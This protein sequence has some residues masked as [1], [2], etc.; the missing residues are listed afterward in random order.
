MKTKFVD[1]TLV[2]KAL[3]LTVAIGIFFNAKAWDDNRPQLLRGSAVSDVQAPLENPDLKG[4]RTYV[5]D[6]VKKARVQYNLPGVAVTI[7][8]D[9]EVVL[10]K[11]YGF[12]DVQ[13]QIKVNP[14][15]TL[16]RIGS[17][18]KTMTALAVMQLVEQ[19]KLSI[20]TDINEYLNE[21]KIP[22]TFEAP[23][24]IR[25]LL[26]HRAGFE[27]ADAGNLFV[28]NASEMLSAERYLA[29]HMPKRIW[30]PGVNVS[31][32]NYGFAL[33]GYLVELQSG[34]DLATYMEQH[35]FSVLGMQ[36]TTL[37]EPVNANATSIAMKPK[38]QQQ[39]ATGYFR[40]RKG[41]NIPKPF[42]FIGHVSGAG[43]ISATAHDMALY[44]SA[45]LSENNQLVQP[46]T[47]K[48]MTR[49]LYDDRALA[50]GIAHGMFDGWLKG[51]EL[52]AHSGATHTFS[53]NM[54]MFPEAQLGIFVSTN[55][56]GSGAHFVEALPTAIFN[57]YYRNKPLSQTTPPQLSQ[58]SQV[59]I[60][61]QVLK[62]Q[63]SQPNLE[64]YTGT[65]L[66]TRRSYTQLEKLAALD[67]AAEVAI[68]DQNRL[69]MMIAGDKVK[70]KHLEADVFQAGSRGA[71]IFYFYRDG[72]GKV[73][74]FSASMWSGDYE[75]VSFLQSPLFFNLAL[76]ISSLLSISILL[77]CFVRSRRSKI[78]SVVEKSA[79][80][81]AGMILVAALGFMLMN[82][83]VVL[84]E[85]KFHA[86][87][88]TIEVKA[89]VYLV[90]VIVLAT[91]VNVLSIPFMLRMRD[92]HWFYK[93]HLMV[94]TL[95]C[96][97][98]VYAFWVWNAVGFNYFG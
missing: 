49:R 54:M 57:K 91:G 25:A 3:M 13:N 30:P 96:L 87:F 64:D 16:F 48:T 40:D 4:L 20:D 59:N 77:L 81:T 69:V 73:N 78:L 9:G 62:Q 75:R 61:T 86:S 32:S 41:N 83:G 26:S 94:F 79:C 68:D 2:L 89:L 29:T 95:S 37:R 28:E 43:A 19:G 53:A 52:R 12:A 10:L 88:P 80:Y 66:S 74:R 39:L 51:Y 11:G 63:V 17:I 46:V 15:K 70:L 44:M 42:E 5:D 36:N 76:A 47:Q 85:Y 18:T 97:S 33:L 58:A 21:F 82:T 90:L 92:L 35:L 45:L 65:F 31:Y 6:W 14:S 22:N 50:T 98:F 72:T 7:V 84:D 24:T 23:I 38:L 60:Y 55:M 93:V 27:E 56:S 34:M 67:S 71:P 8:K 1:I